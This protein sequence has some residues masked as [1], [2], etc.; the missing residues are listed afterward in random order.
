[1]FRKLLFYNSGF[2]TRNWPRLLKTGP[3]LLQKDYYDILG[4]SRS[5]SQ[6]DIKSAYYKLAK[7]YHPDRTKGDKESAKK[8]QKVSEAYEVLSDEGK[9][10]NYDN[11]G[12]SASEN[13]STGGFSGFNS[14]IDPE[15]LFRYIIV[16]I[17]F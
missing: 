7:Q 13:F 3:T 11:F 8:F 5:A 15:E 1:M 9:R 10:K 6:K 17:V 14:N 2:S 16:F 4:V 12:S